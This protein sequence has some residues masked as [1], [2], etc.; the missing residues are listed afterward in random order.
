MKSNC[1]NIFIISILI[2]LQLNCNS[3]EKPSVS[4]PIIEIIKEDIYDAPIKSQIAQHILIKNNYSKEDIDILLTKQ[5]ESLIKRENFKYHKNPTNIYIY[6]YN[7][8]E[9]A[10][11]GQ[12]LWV[13]ML[14]FVRNYNDK[15]EITIREEQLGLLFKEPEVKFGLTEAK[16]KEIFKEIIKA[17][18]RVTKDSKKLYPSDIKKQGAKENELIEKFENNLAKKYNLSSEQI[19]SI[20]MEGIK[21]FGLRI[22]VTPHKP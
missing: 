9:K 8:K 11:A 3:Q 5:F 22:T 13:A 4:I 17:E 19:D 6:V 15:P 20:C 16:R 12:Y 10:L 2:I 1:K 14:Q 21:N 18:R 7:D